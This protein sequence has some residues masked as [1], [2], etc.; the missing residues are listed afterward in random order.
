MTYN[1][2]KRAATY[3]TNK[4]VDPLRQ[5]IKGR[6][7]FAHT[8][9]LPKGSFVYN[10]DEIG[11]MGDAVISYELPDDAQTRD[12][13]SVTN[14]EM[15]LAVISKGFK[16]PVS[17]WQA[18]LNEGKDLKTKGMES[19]VQVM[20]NKENTMLI[21]SWKPDGT[22]A[23]VSG[24]YATP[25]INSYTTQKDFGTYGN[26]LTA[27]SQGIKEIHDDNVEGVNFNLT[28]NSVQYAELQVSESDGGHSE[29]DRVMNLL[30]SEPGQPKGQI[31]WSTDMTAGTG[32]ISPVDTSGSYID[33]IVG[34]APKTVVGYDSKLT[35]ELSPKYGTS[36]EVLGPLVYHPESMCKLT[37]I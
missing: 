36:F 37:Q 14:T 29:W 34:Q 3:F 35:E 21:Q 28:L 30:N 26:A 4:M 12:M 9:T 31:M 11:E 13:I 22:N 18:F 32:L 17:Q 5:R 10:Y 15:K 20:M 16:I 25:G 2:Y 19:A 24:L 7:L 23:K 8:T 1:P 6:K 27:V 33:L